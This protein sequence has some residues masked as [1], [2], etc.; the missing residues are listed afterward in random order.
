MIWTIPEG[1]T[2]RLV[3]RKSMRADAAFCGFQAVV[4]VAPYGPGKRNHL[5]RLTDGPCAGMMVNVPAG[6]LRAIQRG[7]L[8]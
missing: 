1:T 2:V 4:E 5:V 7:P 8:I 3:Y 6:N